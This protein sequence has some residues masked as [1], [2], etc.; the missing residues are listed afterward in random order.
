MDGQSASL[1]VVL[2][3]V[4]FH[5]RLRFFLELLVELRDW[6][7]SECAIT[8]EMLMQRLVAANGFLEVKLVLRVNLS[9]CGGSTLWGLGC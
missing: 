2:N 1:S 8:L 5:R 4:R 9:R 3:F 7:T 6:R